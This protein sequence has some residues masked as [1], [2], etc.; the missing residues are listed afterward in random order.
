MVIE[1]IA[2]LKSSDKP[3]RITVGGVARLVGLKSK[4]IDKLTQCKAEIEKHCQ[5]QEKFWAEKVLWAWRNLSNE[6]RT[7]SI[8]Q[9]R[10][11]TNMSTE[12]IRRSLVELK[13]IN[14]NIYDEIVK[15]MTRSDDS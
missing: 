5:S 8:K 15:L 9:I 7:I 14:Q 3:Q 1:T 12:Q 13:T 11:Q 4:Q 10:L 6:G 2:G